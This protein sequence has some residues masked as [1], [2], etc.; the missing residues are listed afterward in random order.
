MNPHHLHV[1]YQFS[2]TIY[3]RHASVP[4]F[5][6][7]VIKPI[8]IIRPRIVGYL[9][10]DRRVFST[11]NLIELLFLREEIHCPHNVFTANPLLPT[12][13]CT[14]PVICICYYNIF[15]GCKEL[16]IFHLKQYIQDRFEPA[17]SYIGY[18]HQ[19]QFLLSLLILFVQE[20]CICYYV[21][22]FD[23]YCYS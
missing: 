11:L 6:F 8:A 21:W 15:F 20:F 23:H 14:G 7:S 22:L 18:S 4:F 1:P 2:D 3:P 13:I 17:L 12:N 10:V 19:P 9:I 5:I 16:I